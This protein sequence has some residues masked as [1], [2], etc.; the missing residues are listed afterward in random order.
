M[1]SKTRKAAYF[2]LL[3]A[4]AILLD[5][6]F[7]RSGA[8]KLPGHAVLEAEKVSVRLVRNSTPINLGY[9]KNGFSSVLAPALP[10]VVSI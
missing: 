6:G 4:L 2:L 1:V 5:V 7:F 3:S 10:A 8:V 9:F